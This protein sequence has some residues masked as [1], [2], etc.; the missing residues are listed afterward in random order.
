M[1]HADDIA[2]DLQRAFKE[3]NSQPFLHI[4]LQFYLEI[5][6]RV[7]FVLRDWGTFLLLGHP[8]FGSFTLLELVSY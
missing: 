2:C 7:L 4:I 8:T 6:P 5:L 3:K 1:W